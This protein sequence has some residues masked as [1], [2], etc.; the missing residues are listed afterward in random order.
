[1]KNIT[2]INCFYITSLNVYPKRE[3]RRFIYEKQIKFLGITLQKEGFYCAGELISKELIEQSGE[4]IVEDKKVF[5]RD[6]LQIRLADQ[7][8]HELYFFSIDSLNLRLEELKIK[9]SYKGEF[10][11]I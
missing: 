2:N 8:V 5:Y 9:S 7:S 11:N 10:T 4:F 6:C 3:T 1:M